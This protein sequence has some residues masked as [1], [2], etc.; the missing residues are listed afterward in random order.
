MNLFFLMNSV[1]FKAHYVC[2]ERI[3]NISANPLNFLYLKILN[4]FANE[5]HWFKGFMQFW[6]NLVCTFW[7]LCLRRRILCTFLRKQAWC[8]N[9]GVKL[10]LNRFCSFLNTVNLHL[11]AP[12]R[13]DR[14]DF[15][16]GGFKVKKA[17]LKSVWWTSFILIE[18]WDILMEAN[19]RPFENKKWNLWDV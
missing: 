9:F 15:R 1:F 3:S 14:L 5:V 11:L 2:T 7:I 6:L 4:L 16:A 18:T 10:I 19:I 8:F 13:V 17:S 12:S